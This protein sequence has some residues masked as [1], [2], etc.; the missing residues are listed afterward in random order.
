MAELLT[1]KDQVL[2]VDAKL[3]TK[4]IGKFEIRGESS[5]RTSELV[6]MHL[7]ISNV[8][9]KKSSAFSMFV[10]PIKLSID[11][12]KNHYHLQISRYASLRR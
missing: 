8:L 5:I 10:N 9:E 2:F 3:E 6:T 1:A 12:F 7:S 11:T 4:S